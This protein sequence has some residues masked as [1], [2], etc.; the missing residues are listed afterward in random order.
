MESAKLKDEMVHAVDEF[1]AKCRA[2][3]EKYAVLAPL[4]PGDTAAR[5]RSRRRKAI[6]VEQ[7][8]ALAILIGKHPEGVRAGALSKESGIEKNRIGVP[9]KKA[10]KLHLAHMKGSKGGAFYLPA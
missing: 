10:T 9:L 7:T 5:A 8:L 3:I 2:L 1:N 6:I 4:E